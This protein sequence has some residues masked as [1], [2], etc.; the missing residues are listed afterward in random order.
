M[1]GVVAAAERLTVK[2]SFSVAAE[3]SVTEALPIEIVGGFVTIGAAEMVFPLK[4]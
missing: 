1:T 2:V 3:P 4:T